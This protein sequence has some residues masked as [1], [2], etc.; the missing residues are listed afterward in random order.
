M[1]RGSR[2]RNAEG[3]SMTRG[4][5][6]NLPLPPNANPG[7]VAPRTFLRLHSQKTWK[8]RLPKDVCTVL[9]TVASS[10]TA[11]GRN[12]STVPLRGIKCDLC[13]QQNS[14]RPGKG[15]IAWTEGRN[16]WTLMK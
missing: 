5:L 3:E 12:N 11:H 9:F 7:F 2:D 4:G 8:Q 14:V 6:S 16:L 15:D 1:N 10:T 13:I